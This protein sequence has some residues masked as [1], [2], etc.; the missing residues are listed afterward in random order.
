[1]DPVSASHQPVSHKPEKETDL[2]SML[3]VGS[4]ITEIERVAEEIVRVVMAG[5]TWCRNEFVPPENGWPADWEEP[6]GT[7][8][9][10]W[11]RRLTKSRDPNADPITGIPKSSS[12]SDAS[13]I[14]PGN[15][16]TNGTSNGK[17]KASQQQR[18]LNPD[19]LSNLMQ[20]PLKTGTSTLRPNTAPA[21]T[22]ED[23]GRTPIPSD[24]TSQ[25]PDTED[26]HN[27]SQ[28]SK[29]RRNKS[30]SKQ[31]VENIVPGAGPDSSIGSSDGREPILRTTSS[32]PALR[33][34]TPAFGI[35]D[36]R[37]SD[38]EEIEATTSQVRHTPVTVEK[39]EGETEAR[40][41]KKKEAKRRPESMPKPPPLKYHEKGYIPQNSSD[42]TPA[43]DSNVLRSVL[44]N[45][46]AAEM[47]NYPVLERNDW[48]RELLQLIHVSITKNVAGL[49]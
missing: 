49:N 33:V 31:G 15:S 5:G 28:P 44:S 19:V 10:I 2:L 40:G 27:N 1:M 3:V 47:K 48:V 18:V 29:G 7:T 37:L 21:A 41:K 17:K 22:G 42:D 14:R 26:S 30:K 46:I 39:R 32:T 45:G 16:K 43:L 12:L 25:L 8:G 11:G 35:V 23:D 6:K 38:D 34:G 13:T 36:D 4:R 9:D 20:A 24:F